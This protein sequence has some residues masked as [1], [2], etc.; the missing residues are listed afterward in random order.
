[1]DSWIMKGSR[2]TGLFT[3][4]EH[5]GIPAGFG[6]SKRALSLRNC[7]LLTSVSVASKRL[8]DLQLLGCRA[9]QELRVDAPALES[10]TLYGHVCWSEPDQ[11]WQEAN[12][13]FFDFVGDMP[14]LRDAYLSHL[15]CGDYNVVHDMAY[16]YLYYVVA[17]ARI[18]TLCSIGLLVPFSPPQTRYNSVLQ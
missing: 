8:R 15:G 3:P 9:V 18:L 16:P 7:S 1:M 12:P 14:A 2:A 10:L 5:T 11:T 6:L 17:H 13:V 4:V